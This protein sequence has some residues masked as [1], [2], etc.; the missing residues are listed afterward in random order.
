MSA[1]VLRPRD[2]FD[3]ANAPF[4]TI[5]PVIK[6]AAK[7]FSLL[8][9]KLH[10]KRSA[11]EKEVLAQRSTIFAAAKPRQEDAFEYLLSS[12]PEE[13]DYS[14]PLGLFLRVQDIIRE[15]YK[16]LVGEVKEEESED[17]ISH[18]LTIL[19]KPR[20]LHELKL[21]DRYFGS[22]GYDEETLDA[23]RTAAQN[24][25]EALQK[26]AGEFRSKVEELSILFRAADE[27]GNQISQ[28][29]KLQYDTMAKQHQQVGQKIISSPSLTSLAELIYDKLPGIEDIDEHVLQKNIST[30]KINSAARFLAYLTSPQVY[31][32]AKD[33]NAA[34]RYAVEEIR[35]LQASLNKAK[36]IADEY[37]RRHSQIMD[38]LPSRTSENEPSS[39][40]EVIGKIRE[41]DFDEIEHQKPKEKPT[42]LEVFESDL[43]DS[44]YRFIIDSLEELAKIKSRKK[45]PNKE[46]IRKYDK[47]RL[48]SARKVVYSILELRAKNIELE[49]RHKTS[50]RC[51]T[52]DGEDSLGA[53]KIEPMDLSKTVSIEHIRGSGYNDVREHFKSID[54][55]T[56]KYPAVAKVLSGRENERNH[57]MLWGPPG[58]GKTQVM[59]AIAKNP[60]YIYIE[61]RGADLGT[62]WMNET[63]KNPKRVFE[64][65]YEKHRKLRKPVIIAIDEA[66]HL[67][68]KVYGDTGAKTHNQVVAEIQSLLDG[69][70]AYEGVTLLVALNDISGIKEAMM[71]R[72]HVFIVG[73]LDRHDRAH[74][75][76]DFASRGLPLDESLTLDEC[77]RIGDKMNG[78]TGDFL[79]KPVDL[80]ERK[81]L[82][83]MDIHHPEILVGLESYLKDEEGEF[84][85]EKVTPQEREFVK[86][87][88]TQA[89]YSLTANLLSRAVTK[90]MS[91]VSSKTLIRTAQD[92]Y[93]DAKRKKRQMPGLE[94]LEL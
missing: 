50:F 44:A 2:K 57:A 41:V 29:L 71:R 37:K 53:I 49:E 15:T 62:A 63:E 40:D 36:P 18:V 13:S 94:A 91:E 88:F 31:S 70:I 3:R 83:E 89:G 79:R 45:V 28:V 59:R 76:Y 14:N 58:C 39:I 33:A 42:K 8:E 38:G 67:L 75:L 82:K 26:V 86:G 78:A 47:E 6:G 16:S 93:R 43:N 5:V 65:A 32:F 21:Y 25:F 4:R 27:M 69:T 81:F 68:A 84:D 74:L 35:A 85:L 11:L 60:D 80:V 51:T 12:G 55:D 54:R 24:E 66:E 19:S 52:S 61:A 73:E 20:Q 46:E 10:K 87:Q 1:V 17:E 77:Y 48:R 34:V 30:Y 7:K 9:E 23:K 64:L 92:F 56:R 22:K 90:V 72:Y